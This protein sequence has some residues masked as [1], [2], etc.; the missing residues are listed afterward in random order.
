MCSPVCLP[1]KCCQPF[2]TQRSRSAAQTRDMREQ[3]DLSYFLGGQGVIL[4]KCCWLK[5]YVCL[6]VLHLYQDQPVQCL[7]RS[8]LGCVPVLWQLAL[9]VFPPLCPGGRIII[10]QYLAPGAPQAC[11]QAPT[12]FICPC[13]TSRPPTPCPTS[14]PPPPPQP[15]FGWPPLP[16][17]SPKAIFT[18]SKSSSRQSWESVTDALWQILNSTLRRCGIVSVLVLNVLELYGFV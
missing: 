2:T 13:P 9:L 18:F 11:K 6:C 10:S 12:P 7:L 4:V 8:D 3:T 16:P 5:S 17:K 1:L 15:P 14:W